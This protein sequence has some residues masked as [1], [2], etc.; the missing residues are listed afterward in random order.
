MPFCF[1]TLLNSQT[2]KQKINPF[3][4]I[5]ADRLVFN[6]KYDSVFSYDEHSYI[7]YASAL[8]NKKKVILYPLI[9]SQIR[10]NETH[11]VIKLY[12]LFPDGESRGSLNFYNPKF[13]KGIYELKNSQFISAV[14]FANGEPFDCS[15]REY[16]KLIVKEK[17]RSFLKIISYNEETGELK[18]RFR[19]HLKMDAEEQ[20]KYYTSPVKELFEDG[21]IHAK[22]LIHDER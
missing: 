13:K 2:T 3:P 19:V 10:E 17:N 21:V 16:Y 9:Y 12:F 4:L 5:T 8:K 22:V 7:G 18:A 6:N 20:K 11:N 15:H 1:I 14:S